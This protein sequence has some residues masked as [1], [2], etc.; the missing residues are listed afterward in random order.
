MYVYILALEI[1]KPHSFHPK[2]DG[3]HCQWKERKQANAG[4]VWK[5]HWRCALNGTQPPGRVE[6]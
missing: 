6:S 1:R 2:L 4:S 5:E 3:F